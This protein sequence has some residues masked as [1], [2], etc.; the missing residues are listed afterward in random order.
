MKLFSDAQVRRE[1]TIGVTE[2]L[3]QIYK[4]TDDTL[5]LSIYNE[6]EKLSDSELMT[7]KDL[8]EEYLKNSVQLNQAYLNKASRAEN[9]YLE[10]KERQ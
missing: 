7:K 4:V 1:F 2:V 5:K 6:L 3:A 9:E 10:N 8:V